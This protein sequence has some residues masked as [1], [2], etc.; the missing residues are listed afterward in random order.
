VSLSIDSRAKDLS[1]KLA[2]AFSSEERAQFDI[3]N[4]FKYT[5][6]NIP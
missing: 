6:N 5:F 1:D 3:K 4:F 2:S